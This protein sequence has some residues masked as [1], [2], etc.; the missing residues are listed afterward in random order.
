MTERTAMANGAV[1]TAPDTPTLHPTVCNTAPDIRAMTQAVVAHYQDRLG[2]L[3]YA[4]F[5]AI[6]A[7]YFADALPWP[8]SGLYAG[9]PGD[10]AHD[11]AASLAPRRHR[12][13]RS[14]GQAPWGVA[15]IDLKTLEYGHHTLF[16]SLHPQPG[17]ENSHDDR[18][19]RIYACLSMGQA[20]AR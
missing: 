11:F 13:R 17:G 14:V 3:G 15:T 8:L 12:K 5:A 20:G 7:Q 18:T 4:L 16:L 2:R 9:R 19:G 10:A 6:H 1:L